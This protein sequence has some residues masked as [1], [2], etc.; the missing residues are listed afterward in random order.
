MAEFINQNANKDFKNNRSHVAS[1]IMKGARAHE[2]LG[3]EIQDRNFENKHIILR[4]NITLKSS[5]HGI[6]LSM[7]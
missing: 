6:L 3:V 2:V 7:T 1:H 4:Q 5:G